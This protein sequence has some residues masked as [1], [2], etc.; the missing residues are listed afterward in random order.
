MSEPT[1]DDCKRVLD[2][3]QERTRK[4]EV[5]R[6]EYLRMCIRLMEIVDRQGLSYA[7]QEQLRL[8]DRRIETDDSYAERL[9]IG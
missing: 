9:P 7:E 2:K 6:D 1:F 4:A 3:L 8:L 5:A